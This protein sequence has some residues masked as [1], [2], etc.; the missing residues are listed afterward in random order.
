MKPIGGVRDDIHT[1]LRAPKTLQQV[2]LQTPLQV[3]PIQ[4]PR[5][6]LLAR[7]KVRN[8]SYF[9]VHLGAFGWSWFT[10][11]PLNNRGVFT[12]IS[13]ESDGIG[14][15]KAGLTF[16]IHSL[17][18]VGGALALISFRVGISLFGLDISLRIRDN[19]R[20][21]NKGLRSLVI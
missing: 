5:Q 3:L 4:V 21:P 18:R 19:I 6:A 9:S 2:P 14:R 7:S 15:M 20:M 12:N 16:T 17:A 13:A 10:N 8:F 11:S 1:R